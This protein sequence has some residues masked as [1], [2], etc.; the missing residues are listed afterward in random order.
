MTST[1]LLPPPRGA[2]ARLGAD[3]LVQRL[4]QGVRLGE[5]AVVSRSV[6]LVTPSRPD[7]VTVLVDRDAGCVFYRRTVPGQVLHLD[8][9]HAPGHVP[10]EAV[11]AAF[12]RALQ[13]YVREHPG[14]GQQI[15]ADWFDVQT[16][17]GGG[18]LS[19]SLRTGQRTTVLAAHRGHVHLAGLL[20]DGEI[21]FAFYLVSAVEQALMAGGLG[22]RKLQWVIFDRAGPG[23]WSDLEDYASLTDSWLRGEGGEGEAGPRR[24]GSGRQSLDGQLEEA[25]RFAEAVGGVWQA[26]ALFEAL[27]EPRSLGALRPPG[28]SGTRLRD[29]LER[30]AEMC[31]VSSDGTLC[32]L[33]TAGRR[34]AGLFSSRLREIELAMRM[35]AR[36]VLGQSGALIREGGSAPG[37][38]AASRR[39]AVPACQG[40]SG[41]LAV[42]ETVI[43]ALQRQP[44]KLRIG[45][46]DLRFR[47]RL[48][49]R[50]LDLCLLLDASASMEGERMRAA[51]TM[52]RHLLLT[53]SDRVSVLVFQEQ[54]ARLAVPLTRNFAAAE[55][56]LQGIVP[57]GLT[58]LGAGI[59]AARQYMMRAHARRP[60]L[61]LVTDGIPT[62]A[63]AGQSPLEEALQ[64]ADHV[65]RGAIALCCIGLEPNER[66]MRELAA[67]AGGRLYVVPELRPELLAQ[68]A[69]HERGQRLRATSGPRR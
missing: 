23:T 22:L 69:R 14:R 50:R 30:M 58:P 17:S 12:R 49:P 55:R 34:V 28:L 36:G 8:I 67:R 19:G 29:A 13:A 44:E 18:R 41:E 54:G 56:G 27:R 45:G 4:R 42:I 1:E 15:S 46:G 10:P 39:G 21:V 65:R 24:D 7:G 66:Y 33:T 31:W 47:H 61:L 62:V 25:A 48:R 68:V 16:A 3:A 53:S 35:A 5:S 51:K 37:R 32:R 20:G 38:G 60:L 63:S 59:R 43:S 26:Q 52:A 9:F 64:E 57:A 2:A 6:H 40:H 11:A